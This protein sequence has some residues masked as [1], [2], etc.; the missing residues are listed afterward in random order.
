MPDE[1]LFSA[2]AAHKLQARD[3]VVA[4]AQRLISSA[5]GRATVSNFN[6]QLMRLRDYDQ[7]NKDMTKAPAFTPDIPGALKQEVLSFTDDVVFGQDRGLTELLTA[8]YTFANSKVA[9]VYGLASPASPAAGQPD[10]F[11]K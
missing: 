5:A 3:A 1:A 2:A 11:V 10:P 8:P 6:Y 4:Q 7:I 9:K